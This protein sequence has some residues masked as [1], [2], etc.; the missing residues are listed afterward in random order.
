MNNTVIIV[1]L[2][3]FAIIIARV[4]WNNKLKYEFTDAELGASKQE[5]L[6]QLQQLTD[7][8]VLAVE[9]SMHQAGRDLIKRNAK[10][11]FASKSTTSDGRLN[12]E[13]GSEY[14]KKRQAYKEHMSNKYSS[15][16]R[17]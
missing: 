16:I 7:A 10:R 17:E 13:D 6:K 5:D 12:F 4:A 14:R 2:F 15:G 1:I 9:D 11:R 8:E 3:L